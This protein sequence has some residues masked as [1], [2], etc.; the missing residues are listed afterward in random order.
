MYAVLPSSFIFLLLYSYA[1]QRWSRARLFNGIIVVFMTFF[2]V[3]A[4]LL[5]PNHEVTS[6]PPN[7]FDALLTARFNFHPVCSDTTDAVY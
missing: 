5:Y 3:F 6:Q 2:T 7:P 4:F 1:S